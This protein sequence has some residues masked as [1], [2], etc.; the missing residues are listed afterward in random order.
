MVGEVCRPVS[1]Y[2]ELTIRGIINAY[3][4]YFRLNQCVSATVD[5]ES[6]YTHNAGN[7]QSSAT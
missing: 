3:D 5:T 2:Y 7:S 4:P 1:S 6:G